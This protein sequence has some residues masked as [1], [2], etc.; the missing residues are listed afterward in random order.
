MSLAKTTPDQGATGHGTQ[1][2]PHACRA[3]IPAKLV[4]VR[5]RGWQYPSI[6]AFWEVSIEVLLL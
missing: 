6:S 3:M 2:V 4:D 5:Q 1:Q